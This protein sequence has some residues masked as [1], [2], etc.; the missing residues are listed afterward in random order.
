MRLDHLLSKENF[1]SEKDWV[2]SSGPY[3]VYGVSLFNLEGALRF[4]KGVKMGV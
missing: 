1:Q 4:L 3:R 2:V